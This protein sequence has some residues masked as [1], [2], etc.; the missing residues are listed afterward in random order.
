[1]KGQLPKGRIVQTA[2]AFA[3]GATLGSVLTLLFAPASGRATRKR[4]GMKFRSL[5]YATTR[6]L[7]H[8]KKLLAKRAETL[9]EAAVE[10]I[11]GAR[12][13]VTERMNNGNGT[14]PV[15]RRRA[16]HHV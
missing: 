8:A 15:R 1:M 4:I 14:R 12:E 2:G 6:Q 7:G 3:I 13:W 9:R 16:V 10:K 5:Q 11:H